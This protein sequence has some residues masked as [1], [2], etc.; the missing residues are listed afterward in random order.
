[1]REKGVGRAERERLFVQ[2]QIVLEAEELYAVANC[3]FPAMPAL[4]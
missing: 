2:K 3:P 1:M 4:V